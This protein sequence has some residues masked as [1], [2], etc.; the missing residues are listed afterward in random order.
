MNVF[1]QRMIKAPTFTVDCPSCKTPHTQRGGA[2]TLPTNQFALHI[3]DLNES[4]Q[5]EKKDGFTAEGLAATKLHG[6]DLVGPQDTTFVMDFSDDENYL[7]AGTGD[8]RLLLWSTKDIFGKKTEPTVLQCN[9]PTFSLALSP[10]NDRIFSG[11][12]DVS[13]YNVER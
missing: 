12:W 2:G 3:I 11:F 5:E 8:K 10:A 4:K 6:W 9:K 1:L 7:V 13:I